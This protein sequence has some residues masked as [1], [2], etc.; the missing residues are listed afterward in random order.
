LLEEQWNL[1]GSAFNVTSSVIALPAIAFCVGF[2]LGYLLRS[3]I[4]K[5]RLLRRFSFGIEV[6]PSRNQADRALLQS[7]RRAS[8]DAPMQNVAE[9]P[10]TAALDSATP[11][12]AEG[13]AP[14]ANKDQEPLVGQ[15]AIFARVINRALD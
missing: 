15:V 1:M 5:R 13:E 4:S 8:A 14:L 7:I 12:I 9:A 3:N 2:L 6:S 10:M 11:T